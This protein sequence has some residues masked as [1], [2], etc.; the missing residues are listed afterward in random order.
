MGR[1][2]LALTARSEAQQHSPDTQH[3]G[4]ALL[5]A[6]ASAA[7]A[8]STPFARIASPA[9]PLL[10]AAGRLTVATVI[11]G[12]FDAKG[13]LASARSLT[14]KEALGVAL[15]GTL[16]A[17]HFALFQWGLTATSSP[18]AVSLVSLEPLAVVV[19]AWIGF[20]I[21]P[22]RLEQ[23]GIAIATAGAFI[24]GRGAGSGEHRLLG[25]LLVVGSVA[26]YGAYVS[27][28]RGLKNALPA[29]HYAPLVYGAAAL[30][31][32]FALPFVRETSSAALH[33]LPAK[34]WC[35]IALLGIVPTVIGHTLV[36][37]GARTL[38]P[39]VIALVSPGET[40]GSLV[41]LAILFGATPSGAE[42]AGAL[43]ILAGAGVAL[44]AQRGK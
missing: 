38:S 39:S 31:T 33:D 28:A 23:I 24:I 30:V 26:I 6:V 25:D 18:A 9:H 27:F 40:L 14:R 19:A 29:R 35:F 13:V 22:R 42:G 36:Q 11:L 41:L 17:A 3:S 43:A 37:T 32:A 12:L 1:R 34:S 20:G 2:D 21:W 16:L 4:G 10:I 8:T 44:Y 7:F 5:V 15:A